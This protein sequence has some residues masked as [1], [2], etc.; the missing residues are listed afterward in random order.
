MIP[1]ISQELAHVPQITDS[2]TPR[3]DYEKTKMKTEKVRWAIF[4]VLAA[5]GAAA[6]IGCAVC[7]FIPQAWGA[8]GAVLTLVA[9]FSLYHAV[10]KIDYNDPKKLAL[11]KAESETMSVDKIIKK[12]GIKNLNEYGERF[13]PELKEKLRQELRGIYKEI[14]NKDFNPENELNIEQME[15]L[16]NLIEKT[17]NLIELKELEIFDKIVDGMK[18]LKRRKSIIENTEKINETFLP[19]NVTLFHQNLNRLLGNPDSPQNP[20]ESAL[21]PE[22]ERRFANSPPAVPVNMDEDI[23]DEEPLLWPS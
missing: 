1:P 6:L 8:G 12:H 15:K 10:T 16:T 23:F 5:L 2:D 22:I 14:V 9:F 18:E 19:Q 20:L 11:L 17:Y 4:G 3:S 13:V 21:D 7:G